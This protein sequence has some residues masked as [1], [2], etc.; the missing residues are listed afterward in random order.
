MLGQAPDHGELPLDLDLAAERARE[1]EDRLRIDRLAASLP[2]TQSVSLRHRVRR[3]AAPLRHAVQ[4]PR[5]ARPAPAPGD[6]PA[7]ASGGALR[8]TIGIAA[9]NDKMAARWGDWH[10]ASAVARALERRGHVAGVRTLEHEM[11]RPR[12]TPATSVW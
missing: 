5:S 8:W 6:P 9:P 12:R 7:P 3:V 1:M 4:L 11:D 2:T 10:F